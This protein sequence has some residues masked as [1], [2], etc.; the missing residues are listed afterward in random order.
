MTTV[1]SCVPPLLQGWQEQILVLSVTPSPDL[2]HTSCLAGIAG[3]GG[4]FLRGQLSA[5]GTL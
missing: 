1:T 5:Q 3:E 2:P 4:M